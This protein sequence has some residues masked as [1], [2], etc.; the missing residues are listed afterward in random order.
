MA[1]LGTVGRDGAPACTSCWYDL[2]G[3]LVLITMYA[4]AHRLANVRRDPRVALTVLGEDPYMHVSLAG[5][6]VRLWDDP[7]LEVMDRL[8]RRYTGQPWSEREPC[9][10][11]HVA[12]ERWH[13]YGVRGAVPEYGVA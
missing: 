11:A 10:S 12:I 3:E 8:S 4:T 9:V 1:V 5:R 7:R 2:D 6:V 13:T